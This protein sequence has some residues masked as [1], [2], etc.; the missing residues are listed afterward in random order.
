MPT[1]FLGMVHVSL[2]RSRYQT[3][4]CQKLLFGTTSSRKLLMDLSQ[5]QCTS[6]PSPHKESG[7]RTRYL[8]KR[9][10]ESFRVSF[11]LSEAILG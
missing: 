4:F 5:R 1:L 8:S 9:F 3:L 7:F 10:R 2:S 6:F 11:T